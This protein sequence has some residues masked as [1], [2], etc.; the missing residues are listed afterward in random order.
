[1]E[2]AFFPAFLLRVI[3]PKSSNIYE[4]NILSS[5][6]VIVVVFAVFRGQVIEWVNRVPHICLFQEMLSVGC[7]FCGTTRSLCEVSN[8]NFTAA[9]QYNPVAVIYSLYVL[10]QIPLRV[11]TLCRSE[12]L[13]TIHSI[14]RKISVGILVLA[15]FFWVGSLT[16]LW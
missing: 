4:L 5:N 8:G 12:L 3:A 13:P 14:S 9:L 1:V 7:P 6:L 2:I 10:A 16:A 15:L 11:M